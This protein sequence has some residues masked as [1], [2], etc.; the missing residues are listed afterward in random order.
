V[1]AELVRSAR[2]L[3]TCSSSIFRS[4]PWG[5]DS[6]LLVARPDV[7]ESPLVKRTLAANHLIDESAHKRSQLRASYTLAL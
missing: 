4:K 1:A 2:G 6:F 7:Q 3:A 5:L